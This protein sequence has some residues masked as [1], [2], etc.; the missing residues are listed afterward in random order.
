M[1]DR[2]T[3]DGSGSL[4]APGPFP[5]QQV[6]VLFVTTDA[7]IPPQA[8]T[9]DVDRLHHEAIASAGGWEPLGHHRARRGWRQRLGSHVVCYDV[10]AVIGMSPDDERV[11]AIRATICAYNDKRGYHYLDMSDGERLGDALAFAVSDDVARIADGGYDTAAVTVI[12]Q[13]DRDVVDDVHARLT[14]LRPHITVTA[15]LT[16]P[17]L[18]LADRGMPMPPQFAALDTELDNRIGPID[19]RAPRWRRP[20]R[21]GGE[22]TPPPGLLGDHSP[23]D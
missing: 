23:H 7:V 22:A 12:T 10:A 19:P 1:T 2:H 17:I 9:A 21:R 18:G 11:E 15:L 20:W 4:P 3:D 5:R 6:R 8:A 14:Y 13:G 16:D